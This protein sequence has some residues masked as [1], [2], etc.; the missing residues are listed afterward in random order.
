M[1][2]SFVIPAYNASNSI[3]RTLN[4]IFSQ[5]LPKDWQIEAIVVDDGSAD[6]EPLA[7]VVLNYRNARLLRHEENLGMCAGRNSGIKHS[8]G[9]LVAILD[10][11]DELVFQWPQVLVNILS[12]W[13]DECE[14]CYAAC[15]NQRGAVTATDPNYRGYLHLDDI[16]NER[17][18]GE[19]LPIFRGPYVRMKPYVDLGMRK[20]CGIVSYIN[21][22]LDGPFWI[23]NRVLRIYH[24]A[25]PGSISQGWT[26]PTKAAETANCYTILLER[27]GNLYQL[28]AP[29]TY[30][31]KVLRL[32]VYLK[33][34]GLPG[35]WRSYLLGMSLIVWRES[36]GAAFLLIFGRRIAGSLARAVK[37]MGLIRRYG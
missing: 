11:D 25:Q 3:A 36:L 9:E 7:G 32:A 10:A 17:C 1:L 26:T 14:V 31:T 15:Q 34:A 19:Y 35:A 30:R 5:E 8:S 33:L 13:P 4:S 20:S 12:E 24:E 21:F 18:S 23:T 29:R 22:A 28:R 37:K 27:Y 16:L 6:R 2:I